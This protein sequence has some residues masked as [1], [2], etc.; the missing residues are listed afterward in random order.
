MANELDYTMLS[1]ALAPLVKAQE[2]MAMRPQ[3][4]KVVTTSTPYALEDL[5]ALRGMIGPESE[6]LDRA[7]K[8]RENFGYSFANAL[9]GL[10]Q[11]QGPG[12]W[13]SAL[14]RGFGAGYT[15]RTNAEIDRAQQAYDAKM[16][17]ITTRLAIDKAMGD[18]QEQEITYKEM[19]YGGGKSSSQGGGVGGGS[20]GGIDFS[21]FSKSVGYDPVKNQI[22]F[23]MMD[24]LALNL[25][26]KTAGQALTKAG[27]GAIADIDNTTSQ[28]NQLY[29]DI[30][31]NI[32]KGKMLNFI[33]R[34]GG[35]RVAD[36]PEE[37]EKIIGPLINHKSMRQKELYAAIDQSRNAFVAIA[38][39]KFIAEGYK[40]VTPQDL[41]NLYNSAFTVPIGMEKQGMYNIQNK[42]KY[43]VKESASQ[44]QSSADVSVDLDAFY[45]SIGG[46]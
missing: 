20:F 17:D 39:P 36:T 10:P 4:S 28:L 34:A 43:G 31:E 32:V 38:L 27:V 8:D 41:I 12:S 19:P 22:N 6:R 26:E 16:K 21:S 14:G 29:G 25:P 40:D 15:G 9:A 7:L 3:K 44:P 35:V 18:K 2:A 13:V 30:S 24:R 45:N 46:Q 5:L 11:Q 23:D 1:S 42:D 33:Q 37:Q